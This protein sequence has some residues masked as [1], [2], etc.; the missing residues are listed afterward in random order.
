MKSSSQR[1][2]REKAKKEQLE[3]F[4]MKVPAPP[5]DEV[6]LLKKQIE[7]LE[8]KV[9]DLQLIV[10]VLSVLAGVDNSR[11]YSGTA[12]HNDKRHWKIG[13]LNG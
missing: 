8:T 6:T 4:F 2:L 11:R 9:E 12:I 5:S 13:P 3:T 10:R 1:N 7:L